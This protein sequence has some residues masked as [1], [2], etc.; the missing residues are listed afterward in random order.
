MMKTHKDFMW[1]MMPYFA[2]KP[3][4]KSD[5]ENFKLLDD[6]EKEKMMKACCKNAKDCDG[7]KKLLCD[8]FDAND[9]NDDCC[10]NEKEFVCAYSDKKNKKFIE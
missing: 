9:E 1:M 4:F 5:A 6:K 10:W 8:W 2:L 7:F 3:L